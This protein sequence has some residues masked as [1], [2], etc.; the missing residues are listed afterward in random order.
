M[1]Q[2]PHCFFNTDVVVN[3]TSIQFELVTN[4][5]KLPTI[6]LICDIV[7]SFILLAVVFLLDPDSTVR[8]TMRAC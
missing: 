2:V 8:F 6:Y 5:I 3:V 4:T 1:D 7:C